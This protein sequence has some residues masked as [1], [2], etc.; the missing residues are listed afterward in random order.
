MDQLDADTKP[1]YSGKHK[2]YLSRDIVQFVPYLEFKSD[3]MRLAKAVL[4]ELPR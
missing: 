2:K 1:L 4:G 3:P